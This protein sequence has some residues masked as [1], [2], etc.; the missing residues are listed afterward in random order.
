MGRQ[1]KEI[2]T[3]DI[4]AMYQVQHLST[5]QIQKITGMSRAGIVKRL[6]M[7]GVNTQKGSGGSTRI[8]CIC[9]FCGKEFEL[10]RARWRKNIKHFCSNEC[11]FAYLE[12]PN[13]YPWRQGQRL[14]RAIV[15]QYI[16]LTDENVVHHKDG[17]CKNNDIANL[18]VYKNQSDHIRAHRGDQN[19]NPVW[20]GANSGIAS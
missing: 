2:K 14:A 17:D 9:D 16:K 3:Q 12:N 6:R 8:K 11:Y 7:A 4:V 5:G 1:K 20:D 19:V 10:T 13:Y 15:S 18:I